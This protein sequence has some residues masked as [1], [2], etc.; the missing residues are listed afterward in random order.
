[1]MKEAEYNERREKKSKGGYEIQEKQE[2]MKE[3]LGKKYV[4]GKKIQG[5]RGKMKRKG[6]IM[7]EEE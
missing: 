3:G 1:M 7:R 2:N 4:R 6:K 5:A